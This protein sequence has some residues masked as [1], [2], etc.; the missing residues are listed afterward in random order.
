MRG[1]VVILAITGGLA[2]CADNRL[3]PLDTT[4][5]APAA[6]AGTVVLTEPVDPLLVG[7]RLMAAGEYHQALRAYTRAAATQGM[8]PDTLLSIGS[9]NLRLGR[10]GQAEDQFRQVLATDPEHIGALNNLGV[11]LMEQGEYG[12]ARSLFERAFALD[13]GASDAIRDNL[14]LAIARMENSVYTARND[15]TGLGLIRQGQGVYSLEQIP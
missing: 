5:D 6:P 3:A 10:L 1:L 14:M 13:G 11:A 7:D 12:E 9:A 8:T 2:G 15:N 4:M